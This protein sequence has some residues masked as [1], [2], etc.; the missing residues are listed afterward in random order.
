[1]AT[2]MPFGFLPVCL[3]AANALLCFSGDQIVGAQRF[4]ERRPV[5]LPRAGFAPVR[6]LGV[7]QDGSVQ[8]HAET[9]ERFSE[10]E[11]IYAFRH[12]SAAH[13]NPAV[14]LGFAVAGRFM[15]RFVVPYWI[16]ECAGGISVAVRLLFQVLIYS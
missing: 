14:T 1:M 8:A 2:V 16:A 15:W 3:F 5:C 11:R 13:F 9:S 7:G 12:I 4:I 10:P 6:V